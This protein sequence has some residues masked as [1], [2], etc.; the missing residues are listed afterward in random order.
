LN[1]PVWISELFHEI[2]ISFLPSITK[3]KEKRKGTKGIK[4]CKKNC[5]PQETLKTSIRNRELHEKR[6]IMP[7]KA[8]LPWKQGRVP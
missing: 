7:D 1:P 6:V 3:L 4:R 5:L 2:K 8:R